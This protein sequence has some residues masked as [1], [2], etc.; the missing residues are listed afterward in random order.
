MSINFEIW[1][2]LA[3]VT[4]LVWLARAVAMQLAL[5]DRKVL[6]SRSYDGPPDQPQRISVIIAAKDEEEN[7]EACVTSLLEQD[8]PDF[9]LIVI[10]DRSSDGTPEILRRL[11]GESGSRLRVV[12]VRELRDDWFGK[13]NAMRE[14]VEVS[15]G[16]WLCFTD[17]D[18]RQTSDTTLTMAMR[19]ALAHNVDF[20]TLTPRLEMRSTWEKLLQ[21]VC[22]LALIAW[23][24]PGRV[25]DPR[26]KS[27]YANGAFMLMHRD[28]YEA[29]GGHERV[30]N[31]ANEDIQ[32]ARI[33]KQMGLKLRV[34]ENEDLYLTRMYRTAADAW[35]GWS[36]IFCCSL[37]TVPRLATAGLL[38]AV[39]TLLPWISLMIVA[40][41]WVLSDP[42]TASEWVPAVLA[43]AVV[44]L[45][46][47]T[48]VWRFYG[49]LKV[50]RL[51]SLTYF[52]G[53]VVTLGVLIN[54]LL[55]A[56]GL[57]ATQW[58][59]TVY[60]GDDLVG[61]SSSHPTR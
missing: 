29:I 45:L 47:E 22:A 60:R 34:V 43:W 48:V 1:T 8:Y 26:R 58:R 16:E 31:A 6:S 4:A 41:G 10:D 21:P 23:F 40:T 13:N 25:N 5:R 35:R 42:Q 2:G 17:A 53:G 37:G 39:F 55:K 7:I 52:I 38:M 30:R 20:L 15:T 19:E 12:T 24:R 18:C 32:M 36:R 46:Q 11:L 50:N 44:I 57:G 51:W 54:A 33:T 14:G 61:R 27:A 56:A 3:G 9:E 59:G 28:C 49:V